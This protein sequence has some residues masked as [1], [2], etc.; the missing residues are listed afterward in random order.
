LAVPRCRRAAVSGGVADGSPETDTAVAD[1]SNRQQ[2]C[3]L[4]DRP[5]YLPP[6]SCGHGSAVAAGAATTGRG[7]G[8]RREPFGLPHRARRCAGRRQ[9]QRRRRGVQC[10]GA[11]G[12]AAARAHD[13]GGGGGG[14]A[15][16][17]RHGGARCDAGGAA[18]RE[19]GARGGGAGA[20]GGARAA[21][22]LGG[23]QLP[24]TSTVVTSRA[25]CRWKRWH[26]RGG[27]R[28]RRRPR[29]GGG[30][31]RHAASVRG[32]CADR[33]RAGTG[34]TRAVAAGALPDHT[35]LTLTSPRVHVCGMSSVCRVCVRR[36]GL[37]RCQQACARSSLRSC[38]AT[39]TTRAWSGGVPSWAP[40]ACSSCARQSSWRT[41]SG[42]RP[43]PCHPPSPR[44][45]QR[46]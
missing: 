44:P 3:W 17:G 25:S 2:S 43:R 11:S 12:S 28:Q 32:R 36:C 18:G 41:A 38:R 22:R 26:Q 20:E 8:A 21:A 31:P 7:V 29:C 14:W 30:L 27:S 34:G 37:R 24:R 9:Q 33:H 10:G 40:T 5:T 6:P 23:R 16:R 45:M 35:R 1:N 4:A 39:T 19:R 42:R 46:R 13:R 15:R